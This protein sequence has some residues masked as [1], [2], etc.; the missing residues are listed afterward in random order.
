MMSAIIA[1]V[2]LSIA[3]AVSADGF[4]TKKSILS[5]LNNAAVYIVVGLSQLVVMSVGQMNLALTST[6]AVSAMTAMAFMEAFSLPLAVTILIGIACGAFL[7]AIQGL[8]VAKS[9][10]NPFIVTLSLDSVILGAGTAI[11]KARV[12]NHVPTSFKSIFKVTFLGMPV[13]LF[14]SIGIVIIAWWFMKKTYFG[15]KLLA[16]GASPRAAYLAGINDKNQIWF[17]HI[18]SGILAAIAG[19]LIS[20]RLGAAQLSNGS[21]WMTLSFAVA[22]LAGSIMSGGK[23]GVVGTIFGAILFS[24]IKNGLVLWGVS[25][26]WT[27]TFMG[28]LLLACYELR[29]IKEKQKVKVG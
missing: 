5:I 22:V 10:I 20:A 4:L 9:G 17:A 29:R 11:F 3:L 2:V 25:F 12:F 6:A 13:A 27:N 21:E 19:L 1:V 8:L 26:Y 23:V 16:T 18:L 24:M 14:I 28:L 15:R 7:G